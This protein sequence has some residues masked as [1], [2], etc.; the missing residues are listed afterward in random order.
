ME[1]RLQLAR[2]ARDDAQH[3]RGGGLLLQRLAQIIGTL[4]QLVEQSR[5]LDGDDRLA[6]EVRDQINLLVG[7]WS[8]F[9]AVDNNAPD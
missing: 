4:P 2:R 6:G 5:I 7:E 1:H 8:D 3:L 9:L